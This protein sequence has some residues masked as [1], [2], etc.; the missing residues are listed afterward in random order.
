VWANDHAEASDDPFR[1]H[2]RRRFGP[3]PGRL[4]GLG[5]AMVTRRHDDPGFMADLAKARA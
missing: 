4:R 3:G 1:A 2:R 5:S